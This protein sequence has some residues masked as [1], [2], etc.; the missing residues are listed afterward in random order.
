M[1]S[2]LVILPTW[3]IFSG[4]EICSSQLGQGQHPKVGKMKTKKELMAEIK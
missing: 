2:E 3:G 4:R 1:V